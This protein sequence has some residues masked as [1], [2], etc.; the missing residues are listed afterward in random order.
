M[1]VRRWVAKERVFSLAFLTSIR[2]SRGTPLSIVACRPR[3]ELC[4]REPARL[5]ESKK[6]ERRWLV[7]N[8]TVG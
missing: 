7:R 3:K 2:V 6:D 5:K 1:C 8:E 4:P